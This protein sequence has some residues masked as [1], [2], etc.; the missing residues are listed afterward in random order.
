M[1]GSPDRP[2][3]PSVE[4]LENLVS[5]FPESD[6]EV[7]EYHLR[8]GAERRVWTDSTQGSPARFARAAD[9]GQQVHFTKLIDRWLTRKNS[10]AGTCFR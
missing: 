2:S 8:S 9:P 5:L 3:G 7:E 4:I 6:N 10:E 1:T